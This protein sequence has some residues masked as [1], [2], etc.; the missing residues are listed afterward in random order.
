MAEKREETITI[1]KSTVWKFATFLFAVLFVIS[2]FTGGFGIGDD[3]VAVPTVIPQQQAPQAPQ[4]VKQKFADEGTIKGDEDAKLTIIEFSDFECPFCG[5]FFTD[6]LPSITK[7]YIDTGKV[8]LIY[9][10]FPLPFHPSA[11]LSAEAS[12]CAKE[13]GKFWEFHDILF[14]KQTEWGNLG[15]GVSVPKFKQFA[16]DL[17]LDTKKF[18][19]CL[20]TGKYAKEVDDDMA[21]AG[22]IVSGTPTFLIGNDKD[23]YKVL[24]GAQPFVAFQ[25]IIEDAL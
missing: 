6:T 20:D 21:E 19:T 14:G 17:G 12:E 16:S 23:G 3:D 4:V 11:H 5:R 24:V 10:D 2:L 22:S 25:Q 8:K 15:P 9:K 18:D 1:N 7:N 13:Q